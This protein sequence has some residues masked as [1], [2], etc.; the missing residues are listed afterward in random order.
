MGSQWSSRDVIT[1]SRASD[2]SCRRTH[3][4]AVIA[5]AINLCLVAP[6]LSGAQVT[7]HSD[8][9]STVLCCRLHL[10]PAVPEALRTHI[11]LQILFHVFLDRSL[12][13]WTCC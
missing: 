1:T 13:L 4:Q 10:S 2:Q 3:G 9:F 5:A 7:D 8:P 11:L 12:P 6:T